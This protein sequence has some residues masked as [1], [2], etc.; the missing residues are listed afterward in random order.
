MKYNHTVIPYPLHSLYSTSSEYN[1]FNNV[2]YGDLARWVFFSLCFGFLVFVFFYYYLFFKIFLITL[3]RINTL[4]DGIRIQKHLEGVKG[5]T[6]T[7]K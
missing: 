4:H 3:Y 6:H 7:T 2:L 5:Q 1:S